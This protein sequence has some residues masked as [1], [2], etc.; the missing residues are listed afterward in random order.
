MTLEQLGY[1]CELDDCGDLVCDIQKGS[2]NYR[3][4]FCIEDKSF[5]TYGL[6]K[7][8]VVN[9]PINVELYRA[10]TLKLKE[11]KWI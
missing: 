2:A 1:V 9:H 5:E 8:Y 11:L 6:A 10:I 7:G 3:V 4:E